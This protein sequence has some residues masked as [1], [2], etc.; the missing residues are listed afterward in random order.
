MVVTWMGLIMG[1]MIGYLRGD[2]YNI[3]L[4]VSRVESV[5]SNEERIVFYSG[6]FT[7]VYTKWI[8]SELD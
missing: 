4:K 8:R 7:D 5:F 3:N 6:S 1:R 2:L